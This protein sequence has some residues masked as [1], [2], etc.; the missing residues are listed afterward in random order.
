MFRGL[1]AKRCAIFM[2]TSAMTTLQTLAKTRHH[3]LAN[4]GTMIP[5]RL[6]MLKI[7]FSNTSTKILKTTTFSCEV[8]TWVPSGKQTRPFNK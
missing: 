1:L 8:G 2:R 4:I 7:S 5:F 6:D 3:P